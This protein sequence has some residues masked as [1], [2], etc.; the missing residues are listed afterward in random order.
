MEIRSLEI[1]FD[2][3]ILSINGKLVTD[4][5]VI[6][7]LPGPDGWPLRKLYNSELSSGNPGN[8]HV[9]DVAYNRPKNKP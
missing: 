9:I 1:D 2:K 5:P 8:C 7:N 3:N 4:R 6:V